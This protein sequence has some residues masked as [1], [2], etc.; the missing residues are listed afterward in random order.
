MPWVTL[1]YNNVQQKIVE[2]T[3]LKNNEPVQG[4][5][6][7]NL[8][9]NGELDGY[10]VSTHRANPCKWSKKR[11]EWQDIENAPLEVKLTRLIL[12]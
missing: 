9:V 2:L 8:E 4:S 7:P 5:F 3:E 10:F 6:F 12:E 1:L 11:K